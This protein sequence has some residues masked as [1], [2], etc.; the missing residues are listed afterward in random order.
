MK[1]AVH[2]ITNEKVTSIRNKVTV[3]C[4]LLPH[5]SHTVEKIMHNR[6]HYP[7]LVFGWCSI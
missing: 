1:L 6:W 4:S 2:R 5:L 7:V 3:R